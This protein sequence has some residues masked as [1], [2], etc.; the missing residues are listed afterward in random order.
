MTHS[1]KMASPAF[2]VRKPSCVQLAKIRSKIRSTPS[3]LLGHP[4]KGEPIRSRAGKNPEYH[5]FP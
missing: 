4:L 1:L 3:M 2:L 5:I